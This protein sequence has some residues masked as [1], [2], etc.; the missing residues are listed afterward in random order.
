[1]ASFGGENLYPTL[2]EQAASLAFSLVNNHAFIDGNK[3]I[4]HA[5][6]EV[7]LLM[8][9]FEI[10]ARVDDQEQLFLDLAAGLVTRD[11]LASWISDHLTERSV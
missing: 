5:S 2:A 7:F 11:Q 10:D 6:M 9:E 3:R 1:M 8:N 4:G